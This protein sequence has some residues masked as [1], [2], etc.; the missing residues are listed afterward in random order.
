MTWFLIGL[1]GFLAVHSIRIVAP[2][3]REARIAAMGAGAWKGVYALLSIATFGLMIWGYGQARSSP[4]L[5]WVPPMPLRHAGALLVLVALVSLV[6]TYVPRNAIKARLQHPM[7]AATAIWAAAH[8]LVSGWLHAMLLA[9]AFLVWALFAFVSARRRGRIELQT[10]VGM[11]VLTIVIG[12]ALT[13][14]FA[15]HLHGALVGVVPFPR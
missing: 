2:G 1:C 8:L 9:G 14:A 3:W 10:S 6:A 4:V 13:A 15:L 12:L 7:L 11:T 5:V